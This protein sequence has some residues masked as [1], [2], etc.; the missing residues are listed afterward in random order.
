M[1][2]GSAPL[3]L[4]VG[5]GSRV[6]REYLLREMALGYRLWLFSE[7][8][9]SWEAP[10]LSGSTVI[11]TADAEAMQER[12]RSL[13]PEG[14]LSW[15]ETLVQRAAEVAEALGLPGPS[16]LAVM[17]CRDKHETR[18]ALEAANV[19]QARSVRRAKRKT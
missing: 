6:Y 18:V 14:V 15:N 7:R 19:P 9:P 12:A 13:A 1:A 8:E 2:T 16:P 11:D 10:Y 17:R 4:I 3:V 5:T